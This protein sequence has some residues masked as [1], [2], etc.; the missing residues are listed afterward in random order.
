MSLWPLPIGVG[1]G[2][3]SIYVAQ[4]TPSRIGVGGRRRLVRRLVLA[5]YCQLLVCHLFTRCDG[6]SACNPAETSPVEPTRP[7]LLSIIP[8]LAART[9]LTPMGF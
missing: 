3:T 8:S 9:Y 7:H 2:R 4:P 1:Q 5:V 6:A